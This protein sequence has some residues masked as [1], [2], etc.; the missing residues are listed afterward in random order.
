MPDLQEVF[1]VS[2]QK[3]HPEHGALERQHRRQR[4]SARNRKAGAFALVA[5][6]MIGLGTIV[7]MSRSGKSEQP[8]ASTSSA[9]FTRH[10]PS[11]PSS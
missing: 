11:A 9:P 6:L 8:A 4:R 5:A 7:L 10:L 3:V 2:T 1:R